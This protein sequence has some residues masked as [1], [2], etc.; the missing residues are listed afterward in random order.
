LY[1]CQYRRLTQCMA[2]VE[3][4]QYVMAR[5]DRDGKKSRP[6]HRRI[7]FGERTLEVIQTQ[8]EEMQGSVLSWHWYRYGNRSNTNRALAQLTEVWSRL[9]GGSEEVATIILSTERVKDRA[10]GEQA[11]QSFAESM[12]TGIEQALLKAHHQP[13]N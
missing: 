3:H 10:G 1:V 13:T 7:R 8:I 6:I 5:G 9:T 2:D 11:L 4:M 12:L